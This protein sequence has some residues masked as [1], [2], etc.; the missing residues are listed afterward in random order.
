MIDASTLS[1]W[2]EFAKAC[3]PSE[4]F[5]PSDPDQ[6]SALPDRAVCKD[7]CTAKMEA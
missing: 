6:V 4:D 5:D 3:M 2:T 7:G 1:V